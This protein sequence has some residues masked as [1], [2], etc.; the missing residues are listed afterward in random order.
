MIEEIR[1]ITTRAGE[2]ETFIVGPDRNAPHPV[3][4]LLHP[5]VFL[6]MDAPGLG[7]EH[8]DMARRTSLGTADRIVSPPGLISR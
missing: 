4:F 6:L 1:D 8:Y 3:V 7:G 5:V 2:I